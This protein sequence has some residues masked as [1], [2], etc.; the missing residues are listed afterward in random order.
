ME[1]VLKGERERW[2]YIWGFKRDV[3][4][5]GIDKAAVSGRAPLILFS[6]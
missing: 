1:G 2:G 6:Y 5:E 3:T 4:W